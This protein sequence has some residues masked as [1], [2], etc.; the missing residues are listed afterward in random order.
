[1]ETIFHSF[2]YLH[3]LYISFTYIDCIGSLLI[4]IFHNS[5][6]KSWATTQKLVSLKILDKDFE[7]PEIDYKPQQKPFKALP[8]HNETQADFSGENRNRLHLWLYFYTI[9]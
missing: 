5:V 1:M 3:V 6:I 7:S 2:Y 4:F 9:I 8:S